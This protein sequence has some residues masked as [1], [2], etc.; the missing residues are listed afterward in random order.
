MKEKHNTVVDLPKDLEAVN[1]DGRL[2]TLIN[3]ARLG[4]YHDF[5]SK[6][7]LPKTQLISELEKYP[8]CGKILV[9]VMEG[10]YDESMFEE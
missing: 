9:R 8:E 2:D 3:N 4:N 6:Y 7:T 1:K 10:Y 5:R